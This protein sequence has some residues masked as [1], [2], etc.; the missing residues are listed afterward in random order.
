[1]DCIKTR[2]IMLSLHGRQIR[3]PL[4]K[5][6]APH[7]LRVLQNAPDGNHQSHFSAVSIH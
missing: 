7:L 4:Q 2:A 6:S 3:A 5:H 1:L